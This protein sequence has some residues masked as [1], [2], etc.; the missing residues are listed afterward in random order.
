MQQNLE[1]DAELIAR[2]DQ[3]GPRY[4]SYPTAVQFSEAFGESQY[5]RWAAATSN[6]T[7]PRPLS[8]YFHI[9]FCDTICY[10][11]GCNKVVTAN[12]KRAQPYLESL[13][14]EIQLRAAQFDTDR[15]IHQLHWG[16]GTPTYISDA[17]KR[18]LMAETRRHFK[19]LD[20]DSGANIAAFETGWGDGL[21][22]CYWGFDAKGNAAW[23]VTDFRVF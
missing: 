18:A 12:K 4:T 9:P 22:P 1:F 17:E 3:A 20:D 23:L 13:Y 14:R 21:Y 16:G 19:L 2:Y 5:R 8:L 6:E 15:P 7:I 10:Y 11:C